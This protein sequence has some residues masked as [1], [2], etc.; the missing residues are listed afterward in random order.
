MQAVGVVEPAKLAVVFGQER[1]ALDL[2]FV[3]ALLLLAM[4]A[5]VLNLLVLSSAVMVIRTPAVE[6]VVALAAMNLRKR[7]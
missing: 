1:V 6:K 7:R 5:V 3:V 2:V 4:V